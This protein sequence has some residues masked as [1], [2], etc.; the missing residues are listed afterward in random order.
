LDSTSGKGAVARPP[1]SRRHQEEDGHARNDGTL[2]GDDGDLQEEDTIQSFPRIRFSNEEMAII[3]DK[4]LGHV[5]VYQ[6]PVE[7]DPKKTL[8][9]TVDQIIRQEGTGNSFS[10]PVEANNFEI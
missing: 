1:T 10:S 3:K 4:S 9:I 5:I 6:T 2:R 8:S 7:V